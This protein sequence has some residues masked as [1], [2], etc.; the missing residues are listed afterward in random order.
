MKEIGRHQGRCLALQLLYQ[1]EFNALHHE[2]LYLQLHEAFPQLKKDSFTWLLV[3]GVLD[4]SKELDTII[5]KKSKNWK[6]SRLSFVDRNIL[7]I[8]LYEMLYVEDI[9][10]GVTINE[11]VELAK[12]FGGEKSSVFINGIL[13]SLARGDQD[14]L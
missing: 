9:P 11:A 5:E 3:I 7:R 6:F 2:E 14:D 8:A 1:S 12:D 4:R 13:G 10:E